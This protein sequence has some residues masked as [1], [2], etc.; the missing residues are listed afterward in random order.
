M[1]ITTRSQTLSTRTK[2]ST[3]SRTPSIKTIAN[4]NNFVLR[5]Y[6]SNRINTRSNANRFKELTSPET[7]TRFTRS[8][9]K[10]IESYSTYT[11]VA[12]PEMNRVQTRSMSKC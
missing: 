2:S 9:T 5:A 6:K 10:F 3:S 11:G 7:N 12:L 8:R 1:A 4:A